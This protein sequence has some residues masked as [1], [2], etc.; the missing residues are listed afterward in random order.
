MARSTCCSLAVGVAVVALMAAVAPAAA[1]P[2]SGRGLRAAEA[3]AATAPA[4]KSPVVVFGELPVRPSGKHTYQTANQYIKA[5]GKTEAQLAADVKHYDPPTAGCQ[6][7]LA[8]T[9]SNSTED[10]GDGKLRLWGPWTL[11]ED[12]SVSFFVCGGARGT[13]V[14]RCMA[15]AGLAR[16]AGPWARLW[17]A[18]CGETIFVPSPRCRANKK[19]EGGPSSRCRKPCAGDGASS[20]QDADMGEAVTRP[21]WPCLHALS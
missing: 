4:S 17:R 15:W 5:S 6:A 16:M 10:L 21:G 2:S 9:P 11:W 12:M 3:Q 1:R 19:K 14:G 13:V 8:S 7:L 18:A 20:V